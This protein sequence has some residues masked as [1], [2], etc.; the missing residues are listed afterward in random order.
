[1][2]TLRI[3]KRTKFMTMLLFMVLPAAHSQELPHSLSFEANSLLLDTR[4]QVSHFTFSG[5]GDSGQDAV[6]DFSDAELTGTDEMEFVFDTVSTC[7]MSICR[8]G[9]DRYSQN[10]HGIYLLSHDTRLRGL[11]YATPVPYAA[12]PMN[13]GD[14]L[15]CIVEAEGRYCQTL[16]IH[17]QGN[18]FVEADGLG[19]IVL[20]GGDTLKHVLRIHSQNVAAIEMLEPADTMP[21][22]ERNIKQEISDTYSW[23]ARGFRYPV[24]ETRSVACYDDLIM[25]SCRQEAISCGTYSQLSI[26]DEVNDSIRNLK[27]IGE[28]GI[29]GNSII[30][31]SVQ[32]AGNEVIVDFT[33]TEE[34]NVNAILCNAMGMVFR[35]FSSFYSEGEHS[36]SLD[37]S[38]MT[39]DT[40]ILYI[41]VNGTVFSEKV[42]VH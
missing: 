20:P 10:E 15:S 4:L 11:N 16:D 17:T 29:N 6:W 19:T 26:T 40:Y 35:R 2:A 33:L 25:V 28:Q 5:Q 13:Y 36:F 38:G 41:N 37:C 27:P 7:I 39:H 22:R 23:Y 1:M 9:I 31:Y 3:M 21:D 30:D 8:D 34:A 18:R 42:H 32:Y 14:T 24:Y 12:F